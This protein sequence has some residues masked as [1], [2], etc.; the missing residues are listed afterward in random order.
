MKRIALLLAILFISSICRAQA[1]ITIDP[2][3]GFTQTY[4]SDAAILPGQLVKITANK[5]LIPLTVSDSGSSVIGVAVT[6]TSQSYQ[7]I[8]IANFGAPALLVD[9]A[10]AV[11]NY[12][13]VS[14]TIGGYGHC[15]VIPTNSFAV[16]LGNISALGS[17]TVNL[18][19]VTAGG[20]TGPQGA[21][22]APGGSIGTA[23]D[24]IFTAAQR[25]KGPIPWRDFTAYMP[26]GGCSSTNTS[27]PP[28]TGTISSGLPTLTVSGAV[29]F[30]S[31]CAITILH[32]GPTSSLIMP[33]NCSGSASRV[34]NVVTLTCA[35]GHR[36]AVGF[37]GFGVDE[38][39]S[40]SGC[41]DGSFNGVTAGLQ[42]VPSTT[43]AT[44]N[45]TAADSTATGCMFS[46]II[47]WSHG[48]TGATTYYY[49]VSACEAGGGCS[50]AVGPLI[51]TTGNASLT[52][53]NFNWIGWPIVNNSTGIA[54]LACV[55]RSTDNITYAA[56]GTSLTEGYTD[57]GMTFPVFSGC[58]AVPPVSPT[59]DQLTTTIISGGGGTAL[60][61]AANASN[62][63]TAQNVYHDDTPFLNSCVQDLAAFQAGF[64]N[65][66]EYGCF[67]PAGLWSFNSDAVSETNNFN[68]GGT[69][70]LI[71]GSMQLQVWPWIISH[72]NWSF[73]GIGDSGG[74]SGNT[75]FPMVP[76]FTGSHVA[77]AFAVQSNNTYIH[78]FSYPTLKGDGIYMGPQIGGDFATSGLDIGEM[79]LQENAGVTGGSP[80]VLD[81]NSLYVFG[82]N[83]SMVPNNAGM[84]ASIRFTNNTYNGNTWCCMAF[85]RTFADYYG[86][87]FDSP[88]GNNSGI[89]AGINFGDWE[90]ELFGS[91]SY[92]AGIITWDVGTAGATPGTS[93]SPNLPGLNIVIDNADSQATPPARSML[94]IK[95]SAF[96]NGTPS[97][98]GSGYERFA[99]CA[100]ALLTACSQGMAVNTSSLPSNNAFIRGGIRQSGYSGPISI[101]GAGNLYQL[102]QPLSIYLPYGAAG[103]A[104]VF[105]AALAP[106]RT[107]SATTGAGGLAAGTY[108]I[109]I[110]GLDF[111]SVTGKTL[112][113]AET[114]VTVGAA[115]SITVHWDSVDIGYA[116]SG[117]KL[118]YGITGLA[119]ENK[120]INTG[121]GS[122]AATSFNYVF[123]S[124]AG[125]V[126]EIPAWAGT[127]FA[128]WIAGPDV[129]VGCLMCAS[130]AATFYQ[131]GIG[132]PAP[133]V[134]SKLSIKGGTFNI[135]PVTVGSLAAAAAGNKGQMIPVSDSTAVAVEGQACLGGGAN[136]A[137]AFSNGVIWKCF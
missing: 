77:A 56:I 72:G 110:E 107:I 47:G 86:V 68:S 33:S 113:S 20:G 109:V 1:P 9:G 46:F 35:G 5:R 2:Q 98:S 81:S 122:I 65:A 26:S 105:A 127:A 89:G 75:H 123:T 120:S 16:A 49:K 133:P 132:D 52:A 96:P 25:F 15:S 82:N 39:L 131:L 103:T 36:L 112:P 45:Q 84:P 87:L 30:K 19:G 94:Y 66:G 83:I 114:C 97:I 129:S 23:N 60:I 17:I 37:N 74:Q 115:S 41:S 91:G 31:G 40:I 54:K 43:T 93:P 55:Y 102:N 88:G 42:T 21:T 70:V 69:Q 104:P 4:S 32:A 119:S 22:G 121:I 95:G 124:T 78:G 11:G 53:D 48:V 59:A 62:A 57:R 8:I 27:D 79:A 106:P 6:G 125:A 12:I 44:Y 63:A 80:I 7:I 134:G 76:I 135:A 130:T 14:S 117:W 101:F 28:A 99:D 111:Q 136:T 128:S 13:T 100:P 34:S 10:C 3:N 108:C 61:L 90:A 85:N 73:K 24:N 64:P 118:L 116:Y 126:D 137:L 92:P 58:P 51:I 71:A 38:G 18:S 29:D 50:T 67:I